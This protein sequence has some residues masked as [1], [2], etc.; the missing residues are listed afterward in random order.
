M[1]PRKKKGTAIIK[2]EVESQLE[3][4]R[5]KAEQALALIANLPLETQAQRDKAGAFVVEFRSKVQALETL[6]KE[7]TAPILESKRNIDDR[8]KPLR[9]LWEACDKALTRRLL[10]G[11]QKAKQAQQMALALVE[12]TA[13]MA[14]PEVLAVAHA[15][16]E[17]PAGLQARTTYKGKVVSFLELPDEYKI[18][19]QAKLDR[20]IQAAKGDITIP[21]VV[22]EEV[23]SYARGRS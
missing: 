20:V 21:G 17:T 6:R 19:D 23:A 9:E 13:G 12:E 1:P 18:V 8:F 14:E 2:P 11:A 16:V 22:V 4:N 3:I 15:S 10:E 5:E 7:L